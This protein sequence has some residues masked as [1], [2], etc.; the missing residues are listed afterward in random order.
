M[1]RQL[2][3]LYLLKK[4]ILE[5]SR[6]RREEKLEARERELGF[7][8]E[9][10]PKTSPNSP[11]VL[12]ELGEL[13]RQVLESFGKERQ[14]GRIRK[15][16]KARYRYTQTSKSYYRR[17]SSRVSNSTC[18]WSAAESEYMRYDVSFKVRDFADRVVGIECHLCKRR[19]Q[20][21]CYYVA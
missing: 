18:S 14:V 16:S 2:S 19:H 17:C 12:A 3:H 15:A 10:E 21:I 4:R 11:K 20:P 7:G 5:N 6:G 1:A 13:P 8:G 9:K